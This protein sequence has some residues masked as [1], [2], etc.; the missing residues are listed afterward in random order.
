VC[1][2]YHTI[3]RSPKSQIL[4]ESVKVLFGCL[5]RL[6]PVQVM[7]WSCSSACPLLGCSSA[8]PGSASRFCARGSARRFCP[9]ACPLLGCS[10]RICQS[11]VRVPVQVLRPGFVQV[12][13]ECLSTFGLH[14]GVPECLSTFGF[15]RVP[16]QVLP[17]FCL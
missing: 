3:V 6:C 15:V 16:V 9:G 12:L 10:S 2:V 8:C 5:S 17:R 4:R 13:P 11:S 7:P 1:D 14:L